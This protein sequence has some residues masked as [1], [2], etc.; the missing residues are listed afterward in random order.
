MTIG[1]DKQWWQVIEMFG[2]GGKRSIIMIWV[3]MMVIYV[4]YMYIYIYIY[5]YIYAR[6]AI[7]KLVICYVQISDFCS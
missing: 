7:Y 4:A 5:I 3:K 1:D 6:Y 2:N